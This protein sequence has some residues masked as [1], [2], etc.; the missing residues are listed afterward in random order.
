[1][2]KR[3]LWT[4]RIFQ[5]IP[6]G[7]ERGSF[8]SFLAVRLI[9]SVCFVF[10]LFLTAVLVVSIFGF[11]PGYDV[12]GVNSLA[13]FGYFF[14]VVFLVLVVS[15]WFHNKWEWFFGWSSHIVNLSES[16]FGKFRDRMEKFI[17]SSFACLVI[18]LILFVQ[19]VIPSIPFFIDVFGSTTFVVWML[20]VNF[21][22]MLLLG[23][24]IWIIVS[25][26]IT[27]Y[28]T[29]RHPL[30]LRL[31]HRADEEFQPLAMWGLKVLFVT[32]VLVA[33][34]VVFYNLGILFSPGGFAGFLGGLIFFVILGV[35]AFLLPFYN[36]HRVLVKLKKR[37]LLEI[38]GESNR[39]MQDLAETAS[40][41]HVLRSEERMTQ[42]MNSL[43]SLQVLQ[44]REKRAKEA[45]EW[46]IDTTVLSILAGIVLVPILSQII[47]NFLSAI[48][49]S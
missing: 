22:F 29:L 2:P 46:P 37:E 36:V 44:I 43:V 10:I 28:V 27:F 40:K 33:V 12:S 48:F 20:A 45:D 11:P 25:M 18:A 47:I 42:I 26:W 30:N 32:F 19:A 4:E 41:N 24:L 5:L 1:L 15:G 31:S 6:I 21:L 17:S 39:L 9:R 34:F 13:P 3:I 7:R 38:E 49:A 8:A 14:A 23:T 16:E 35:V